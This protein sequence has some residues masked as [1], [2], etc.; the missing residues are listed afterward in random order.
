VTIPGYTNRITGGGVGVLRYHYSADSNKRPGT[1]VGDQ[2]LT[3]ESRAYPMGMEDPRWQ[4]EMEIKYGA[5]GGQYLFPRWETWKNNGHIVIDPYEPIGC[6]LYGSYD[7]G[8]FNPASFHVHAVDGDG[9]ITTIW[10]MY[11][12]HIPVHQIAQIIRGKD[13]FDES[14][15]RFA[16][17]PYTDLNFTIAD[18]SIWREDQ[19]QHNGP[20]KSVAAIF[21][22]CNVSLIPGERGG[23]IT[24]AEWLMG[25]FWKDPTSPRYRITSTCPKLIWEIGQQRR[26]EFSAQVALN[27]SQPEEL[28]DK[29]NHAWDDLKY[30]LKRFPPPLTHRKPELQPNTFGWWKKNMQRAQAGSPMRTYRH[31]VG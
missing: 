8:W 26:K 21:R 1:A 25:W 20:N 27:R 12:D 16:G 18:P 22:D 31:M 15:K 30:F 7:H 6:R 24:I 9:V 2:W 4:K 13:G 19:P 29:N 14:G 23:D 28:V 5:M 10:E 3:E 17:C 11:G